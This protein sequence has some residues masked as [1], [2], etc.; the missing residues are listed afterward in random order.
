[1]ATIPIWLLFLAVVGVLASVIEAGYRLGV[2]AHRQSKEEKESPVAAVSN[3]TLG[4]LAFILAFTFAIV[5]DR[6]DAK[7]RLVGEE[8]NALR[9]VYLRSEFLPEADRERAATL[10]R[11]YVDLK[12]AGAKEIVERDAALEERRIAWLRIERQLWDM[13]VVNARQ[14]MDSDV[15]ALYVESLNHLVDAEAMRVAI[16][17]HA[18]IPVVIWSVLYVITALAMLG[19]GYHMGIAGSRRTKA[20]LILVLAFSLMIALIADLDRP[21]SG[22]L[23][24]S[25]RPLV[26]LNTFMDREAEVREQK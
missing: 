5:T 6:Y 26:E 22:F 11:Q 4:L 7:K 1:M 12:L 15:A 20:A 16:A 2:I 25:Q 17:W 3:T 23:R 10:L 14:D 19:F 21:Q 9:T 24:V 8:A 18:R 13:A